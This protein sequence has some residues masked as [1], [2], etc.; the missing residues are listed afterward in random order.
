MFKTNFWNANNYT[1][2]KQQ[3]QQKPTMGSNYNIQTGSLLPL[4]LLLLLLLLLIV[5]L[6]FFQEQAILYQRIK[7]YSHEQATWKN[8]PFGFPP[9]G[10]PP[11]TSVSSYGS[12][13]ASLSKHCYAGNK[14]KPHS[15]NDPSDDLSFQQAPFQQMACLPPP[16]LHPPLSHLFHHSTN[17]STSFYHPPCSSLTILCCLSC[18]P[19]LWQQRLQRYHLLGPTGQGWQKWDYG[20][21]SCSYHSPPPNNTTKKKMSTFPT[22]A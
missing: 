20:G 10:T 3:Q 4:L 9:I 5:A 13:F 22:L 19:I 12:S 6:A 18:P 17:H 7:K 14:S 1:S 21:S 2:I 11:P 16:P 15:T 8:D